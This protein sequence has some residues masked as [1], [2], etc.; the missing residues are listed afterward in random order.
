[1]PLEGEG[2]A[3]D[4]SVIIDNQSQTGQ[5]DDKSANS[6][7][8]GQKSGS[9]FL[10]ALNEENRQYAEKKGWKDDPNALLK[11]YRDLESAYSKVKSGKPG[12]GQQ[13]AKVGDEPVVPQSAND[14]EFKLPEAFPQN[15][16]Y[17]KNFA[18]TFKV[19]SHKAKL[20]TAQAQSLHDLYVSNAASLHQTTS[21]AQT[22][23][24]NEK[25]ASAFGELTKEWGSPDTPAFKRSL[26]LG[27]RA[28][29]NLDPALKDAL[30]AH[31]VIATDS[32]G[33]EVVVNAAIF[34]ALAKA[35]GRL[36]AE[37]DLFGAPAQAENPF[38]P[39]KPNATKAG[40]LLRKNP[41]LARTLIQA[42]GP[43]A[44]RDWGWW[45]NQKK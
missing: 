42:A 43:E 12:D 37:D 44:L 14:Y 35:G 19:W 5:K 26:E 11:S 6:G 15:G 2:A 45:L 7:A 8:D 13:V 24:F 25:V 18:E 36:F 21:E 31:G 3:G 9:Q 34:K 32:K 33:Q 41:E 39:K 1:M 20:T 29:A 30:K 10:T 28:M 27:R 23:Q 17:D 4:Q 40:E 16:F 38:D 22:K